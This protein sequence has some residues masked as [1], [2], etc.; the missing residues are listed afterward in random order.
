MISHQTRRFSAISP[1]A[2]EKS[3]APKQHRSLDHILRALFLS[4][5]LL[6]HRD[7]E[8]CQRRA[9]CK[10]HVVVAVLLEFSTPPHHLQPVSLCCFS[11]PDFSLFN[12]S[13]CCL[14]YTAP[15]LI[16]R[17]SPRT[18]RNAVTRLQ[19][20]YFGLGCTVTPVIGRCVDHRLNHESMESGN[21]DMDLLSRS[22]WRER[23]E[24]R[25][26]YV[27]HCVHIH[28]H[29][30]SN[31]EG[32]SAHTVGPAAIAR[33]HAKHRDVTKC[34][35]RVAWLRAGGESLSEIISRWQN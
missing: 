4:F 18:H 31:T 3:P 13:E 20:P 24:S 5:S 19:C 1:S 16:E 33:T 10:A 9:I 14:P 25:L 2:F 6:S 30:A 22:F 17:D 21:S 29:E 11:P 27:L 7:I 34:D 8:T 23:H 35:A 12:L 26:C 28:N 32:R 15:I